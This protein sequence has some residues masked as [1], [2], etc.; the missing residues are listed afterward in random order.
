MVKSVALVIKR[1]GAREPF[2]ERKVYASCYAA[3]INASIGKQEAEKLC[4][5]V[6][7]GVK[8]WLRGKTEIDS[9][10]LFQKMVQLLA[11][12][13]KDAAFMYESHRDIS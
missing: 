5:K 13:H 2:D 12:H 11:R 3:A 8:G 7:A 10:A 4:E 9:Q 6:T 1:R